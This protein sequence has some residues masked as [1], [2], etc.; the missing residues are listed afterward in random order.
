MLGI[1]QFP[2][3]SL[4]N[5]TLVEQS[6]SAGCFHC[7]KIFPI[8]EITKYTDQGKTC[9]CPFC[10]IDSVVGDRCGFVLDEET[11]KKAHQYWF[12]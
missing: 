10:E 5:R 4:K 7:C 2:Q 9:L 3:F 8:T 1:N 12:N 6:T 11:L